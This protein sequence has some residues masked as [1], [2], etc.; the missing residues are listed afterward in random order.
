MRRLFCAAVLALAAPAAAGE[1]PEA[2]A[3]REALEPYARAFELRLI[4]LSFKKD[5]D[6]RSTH[7]AY[8]EEKDRFYRLRAC[9]LEGAE[10]SGDCGHGPYLTVARFKSAY[11]AAAAVDGRTDHRRGVRWFCGL[12]ESSRGYFGFYK[13]LYH[14]TPVASV[15]FV[16]GVTDAEAR[17]LKEA[18]GVDLRRESRYQLA[19]CEQDLVEEMKKVG[20]IEKEPVQDLPTPEPPEPKPDLVYRGVDDLRRLQAEGSRFVWF[21][22][23]LWGP[24]TKDLEALALLLDCRGPRWVGDFVGVVPAASAYNG[25]MSFHGQAVRHADQ[26]ARHQDIDWAKVDA[27]ARKKACKELSKRLKR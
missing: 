1:T 10:S 27:P 9:V 15:E 3:A 23:T 4:P 22:S 18:V 17:L 21:S 2:K 24:W 7:Y 19:V 12:I 6:F 8:A 14:G 25:G 11:E 20:L 26:P 16:Q 13:S 5:D